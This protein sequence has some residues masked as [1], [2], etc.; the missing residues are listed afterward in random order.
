M[1]ALIMRCGL[2]QWAVLKWGQELDMVSR[3]RPYISGKGSSGKVPESK[4]N[5]R[6][7]WGHGGLL[8]PPGVIKLPPSSHRAVPWICREKKNVSVSC[9]HGESRVWS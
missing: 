5:V 3:A 8:G 4:L 6:P 7:A 9:G 2:Y 1:K